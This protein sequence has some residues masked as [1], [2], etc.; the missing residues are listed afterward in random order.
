[1]IVAGTGLAG[2]VAAIS[3]QEDGARVLLCEKG[4][5]IGGST[6]MSG[7]YLWT[8]PDV[9]TYARI[10][11][12]GDPVLG[13]CLVEDF[14][15]GAEWLRAHGVRLGNPIT[16]LPFEPAA[17]GFRIEP[18]T[19]TGAVLP[20]VD[21][22]C[23]GGG[24][25][26]RG[27]PVLRVDRVDNHHALSV[28]IGTSTGKKL[29]GC[30]S[31]VLATGGFQGDSELL[32]RYIGRWSDRL[33]LRAN[34]HSVGDGYRLAQNFGAASSRGLSAFY[35]HLMPAAPALIEPA[36]YRSLAA[37]YSS[38]CIL[39][40]LDGERFTDESRGDHFSAIALAHQPE[41]TGFLVF[42]EECRV[43]HVIGT[44]VPDMPSH[45]PLR[46]IRAALGV[47]L[48][49]S[50]LEQLVHLLGAWGVN[51]NAAERTLTEYSRAMDPTQADRLPVPR[52]SNR[53]SLNQPP[54]LAIP[55]RVGITFTEGGILIDEDCRV[56][57]RDHRPV[58]G[59][60]AAGA[61]VGNI[62]NEG[63]AGGLAAALITG[64]RAGISAARWGAW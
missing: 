1:V 9:Q 43:Q 6:A 8:L 15:T 28:V 35:G 40:N 25:I 31:L 30:Q 59:L 53:H 63:Y 5:D 52:R 13:R 33:A 51:S 48:E 7:G 42:D 62:S 54:Y 3:A 58:P 64:L 22:F 21:A 50:S 32:A 61:D 26:L 49:A 46:A 45:D 23:A 38:H 36:A 56:L 19:A 4:V 20:L 18:D 60:L 37:F 27:T 11:P 55:V 41:A 10:V 34:V 39:L 47:I 16:G 17:T 57:D 14:N 12:R 44:H 2:L 24:R 29:V